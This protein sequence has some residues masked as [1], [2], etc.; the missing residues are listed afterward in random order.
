[1]PVIRATVR[2]GVPGNA[3]RASRLPAG[4]TSTSHRLPVAF[5]C[6][7]RM[8]VSATLSSVRGRYSKV[9]YSR[10]TSNRN[11][12][13]SGLGR[14][15]APEGHLLT[16]ERE[17][18]R[19]HVGVAR[20]AVAGLIRTQGIDPDAF[21]DAPIELRPALIGCSTVADRLA[22]LR[23]WVRVEVG[24]ARLMRQGQRVRRPEQ[25]RSFMRIQRAAKLGD[26]DLA[27]DSARALTRGSP[28][29]W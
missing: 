2:S 12:S 22:E 18:F 1:M 16:D 23:H 13:R 5:G 4:R 25:E 14:K 26:P 17:G 9:R 10:T 20:R 24:D 8:S 7:A 27:L 21:N 3:P 6:C 15:M 11:V 29:W 28:E 19:I